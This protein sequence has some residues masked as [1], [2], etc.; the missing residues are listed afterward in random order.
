MLR[1]FAAQVRRTR[2]Q[3]ANVEMKLKHHVDSWR[4]DVYTLIQTFKAAVDRILDKAS[5]P[6]QPTESIPLV[7]CH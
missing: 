4:C 3:S 6:A 2:E 1:G 7:T 5:Q